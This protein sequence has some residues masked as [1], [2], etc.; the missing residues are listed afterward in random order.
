ML[1]QAR[2]QAEPVEAPTTTPYVAS[3]HYRHPTLAF[4]AEDYGSIRW[5]TGGQTV[6]FPAEGGALLIFPRSASADLGWV[7]SVLPDGALVAAPPGPDGA[8]A[9]HAYRVGH[10]PGDPAAIVGAPAPTHPLAADLAHV[11]L[12]LGYDV[13]GQP[14]SGESAEVAVWWR[15]L[16]APGRG[17]YG[18]VAR[19]TDPWGFVWGEAYP[20]HYPSEQWTPGEVVVDHLS[21]PVAVGAPPGDYA[22]RFSLYSSGADALLPVLDDA[23]RYAGT[24]VELDLHLDRAAAAPHPDTLDALPIRTRL[25]TRAGGLTLL[26]ANLDTKRI[27]PGERLYLTLFWRADTPSLPDTGVH[28][29][30]GDATLYAGA[31]IHGTYPTSGWSAG[32]LV[33]DRYDPRLPLDT[34]PG[35]Y[36]LQ[37][38]LADPAAG[39]QP[40]LATNLGTVTVEA[41]ERT[42]D[43][44]PISHPLSATLGGQVQ[45]LGYDLE[46]PIPSVVAPGDPITLT[47]YWRALTEMEESYTVFTHL[48]A[49]DGSMT[50]QQDNRP[51]GGSYPTNLWLAGEVV[52]D[53]YEIPVRADAAPGEHRLE[54]GMYVAETGARLPVTDTTQD[55]VFLQ[56]IIVT[57]RSISQRQAPRW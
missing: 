27:R 9:F 20:F 11:A 6:V 57:S 41:T 52:T 13:V 42:F 36:P 14:R 44:P 30:L 17:D 33:V 46:T 8:P 31:P 23:G 56:T 1:N 45:L 37:L 32:E 39:S 16:N 22:V 48:L 19:L 10:V 4:L 5:L 50:G 7:R 38:C 35:D 26:G 47:L 12:L 3:I 21:I 2:S 55:A 54:V 43:V 28:L 24:T 15:V 25:D 40:G 29:T 51:V 18:P 49:P 34:P 53:V